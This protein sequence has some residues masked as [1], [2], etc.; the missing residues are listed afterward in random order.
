MDSRFGFTLV[1]LLMVVA[2]IGILSSSIVVPLDGARIKARDVRRQID[3]WQVT[4]AMELDYSD[5]K[6]YSVVVSSTLPV[7]IPCENPPLCN[8]AG[9]GTYLDPTPQD[10][11]G[12]EYS[13]I[14][15]VSTITTGCSSQLYCVYMPLEEG[16]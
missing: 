6:K 7:K 8:G 14:D 4:L 15:N 5:E 2:I 1:E 16:G 10:P 3:I 11:Q 12:I 9:D 13:W